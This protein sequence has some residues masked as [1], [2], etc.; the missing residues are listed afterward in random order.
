MMDLIKVIGNT[1]TKSI[2]AGIILFLL[3][4]CGFFAGKWQTAEKEKNQCYQESIE[5]EKRHS[6]EKEAILNRQLDQNYK[7]GELT[8]RVNNLT[9]KK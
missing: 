5:Q 9:K 1:L 8:A 3:I 2:I 7:I 4:M 6:D